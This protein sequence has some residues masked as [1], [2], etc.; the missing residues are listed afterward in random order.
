MLVH[1]SFNVIGTTVCLAAFGVMKAFFTPALLD[2]AATH[3]GIATAHSVFNIVCT[4]LLLPMSG[5]LEKLAYKLIPDDNKDEKT[6]M[7]DERLLVTPAIALECAYNLTCKMA[8][9]ATTALK[10]SIE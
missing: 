7:L 5:L 8:E 4:L 9:I 6:A 1:L 2:E 3:A 10:N